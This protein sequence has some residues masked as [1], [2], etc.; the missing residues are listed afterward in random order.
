MAT[1]FTPKG[2]LLINGVWTD[3]TPDVLY[4]EGAGFSIQRGSNGVASVPDPTTCSFSLDNT[5]GKYSP[6]NP[7]GAF[8]GFIGRNTPFRMSVPQSSTY[9]DLTGGAGGFAST[10]HAAA[11]NITG[12]ID[13]RWELDADETSSLANRVVAGKWGSTSL[14][15]AWRI[16][17][18]TQNRYTFE[19]RDSAGNDGTFVAA[20]S[21][22]PGRAI[23]I[24][25]DVDN[26]S[27]GTTITFY[28][29][30]SIT[31]TWNLGHQE[32]A[33]G[34]TTSIQSTSTSV[35]TAGGDAADLAGTSLVSH[36]R[37]FELRS[38]IGGTVV[39]NPNFTAQ[40][41]GASS[42]ADGSGRTWTINSPAVLSNKDIRMTGEISE[43]PSQWVADWVW[44]DITAA[45]LQRRLNQGSRPIQSALR[46]SIPTDAPLAYWPLEEGAGATSGASGLTGTQTW[47]MTLTGVTFAGMDGPHGSGPLPV[48]AV[49]ATGVPFYMNGYSPPPPGSPTAYSVYFA[50]YIPAA[51]A[52]YTTYMQARATGSA[53]VF[54]V[55][56]GPTDSRILVTASDGTSLGSTTVATGTGRIGKWQLVHLLTYQS[57]T[58]VFYNA[59]WTDENNSSVQIPSDVQIVTQTLGR[60]A[61]AG[62]DSFSATTL[63]GFSLGHV[64]IRATTTAPALNYRGQSGLPSAF[65]GYFSEF[66][67]ERI[68]R[69]AHENLTPSRSLGVFSSQQPLGYQGVGPSFGEIQSAAL[70]DDGLLIDD[71]SILAM[72]YTDKTYRYTQPVTSIAYGNLLLG[73][74]P[75]TDDTYTVNSFT[76]TRDG[77]SDGVFEKT[78]GVLNSAN[79]PAGV[80]L[81][82]SS[83]TYSLYQDSQAL[84]R[85]GWEVAKGTINAPRYTNVSVELAKDSNAGVRAAVA[86]LDV[87]G[88]LRITGCPTGRTPPGDQNLLIRG[89]S[90]VIT[91]FTRTITFNCVQ[92]APWLPASALGSLGI[93]TVDTSGSQLNAGVTSTATSLSV[94]TTSGPKWTVAAGDFPFN[95]LVSGELM[96]V[97]NITGAASPQ[98]FTVTRSVNGIVKAQVSGALVD[99]YQPAVAVL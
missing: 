10:P 8:Y 17:I 43:W 80:G 20:Q 95:I 89:Y 14:Q 2:E 4:N 58:S 60:V 24:T 6:D 45:G 74:A 55:Q 73:L 5:S 25:L 96:T 57:G 3:I 39:A 53:A 98:T 19:W 72:T 64:S 37:K 13:I 88:Y 22:F 65:N 11:I 78:T 26:G 90:E 69:I 23:R 92:Y 71:R 70:S 28:Y 86:A 99:L 40:T 50:V 62:V 30:D 32:I 41:A 12:D 48:V 9:L 93:S 38:S 54:E 87:G 66:P 59:S 27:G 7:L 56:V 81:Y 31:G 79:P 77:G 84:Q 63:D 68:E 94:A 15:Q 76:A 46:R 33:S 21:S 35:L 51:P 67:S 49:G 16:Y 44:V 61:Y 47:P 1:T 42:F 91:A 34:G 85:A 82:A 97:T 83:G 29:S 36:Y 52:A 18:D 75:I